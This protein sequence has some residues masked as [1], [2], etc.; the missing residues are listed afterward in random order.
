MAASRKLDRFHELAMWNAVGKLVAW[1]VEEP[2]VHY[3]QIIAGDGRIGFLGFLR[4]HAA[5]SFVGTSEH[6]A[7][8]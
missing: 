6:I 8:S 1:P 5:T 2:D 3:L 7:R 4:W